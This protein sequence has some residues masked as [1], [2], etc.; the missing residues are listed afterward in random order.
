MS[1]DH[2]IG[3]ITPYHAQVLKLRASLHAVADQVK[4]ASVEDF[5]GQVR[6]SNFRHWSSLIS[7]KGTKGDNYVN[8]KEQYRVC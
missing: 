4:V 7:P 6:L 2:D 5:Q 3:V 8:R 1:A